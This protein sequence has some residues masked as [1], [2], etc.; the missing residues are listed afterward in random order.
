[1]ALHLEVPEVPED[2]GRGIGAARAWGS[3][4]AR[5]SGKGLGLGLG[6]VQAGEANSRQR[7]KKRA[8]AQFQILDE[9]AS[10]GYCW[11]RSTKLGFY[12]PT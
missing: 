7:K 3:G 12:T 11:K 10:A 6:A 5:G 2:W 1:M 9:G 8:M 4:I